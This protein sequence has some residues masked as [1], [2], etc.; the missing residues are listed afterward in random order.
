MRIVSRR[1]PTGRSGGDH[2]TP[3]L[4]GMSAS[5][6]GAGRL[7]SFRGGVHPPRSCVGVLERP[8][9]KRRPHTRG[10]AP[11]KCSRLELG[12]RLVG[13]ARVSV[14]CR[15]PAPYTAPAAPAPC[16]GGQKFHSGRACPRG[17]GQW[18]RAVGAYTIRGAAVRWVETP[19]G[20]RCIRVQVGLD[21]VL[22][23]YLWCQGGKG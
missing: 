2:P 20:L 11:C 9:S 16:G 10:R 15:E 6:G 3:P 13:Y 8:L 17:G 7:R 21:S 14:R 22:L 18:G 4:R 19:Y 1:Y 12:G 23:S 5:V